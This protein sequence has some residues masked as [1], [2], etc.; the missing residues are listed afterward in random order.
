M[1][2][3]ATAAKALQAHLAVTLGAAVINK[4]ESPLM[5]AVAFGFDVGSVFTSGVPKGDDFMSRYATTIARDIYLPKSIRE[6]PLSLCEVMT[7]ECEHVLQYASTN[8]EFA[9]FYLT[10]QAA[11]AQFEADAYAS[12]IAVR[13]WLTG[14]K[15]EGNIPWVLDSLVKAYH[16]RPED[17][18]YAEAALKSHVASI[19]S[20]ICMTRSARTAI[21]F[22]TKNY[23]DLKGAVRA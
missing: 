13:C 19:N 15:P 11:R 2:D 14:E 3:I 7:H 1:S 6:N 18:T 23:P 21:E 10:D 4:E 22:L 9:W 17:K 16:L 12:G 5:K 20:G 8:V